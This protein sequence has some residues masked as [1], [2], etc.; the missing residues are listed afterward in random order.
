MKIVK[1]LI[2]ILIWIATFLVPTAFLMLMQVKYGVFEGGRHMTF[3]MLVVEIYYLG[4]VIYSSF[5]ASEK[6]S[7]WFDQ[8]INKSK[9]GKEL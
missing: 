7:K 8:E 6:F 9:N 4:A 2:Q 5:M 1:F 3:V